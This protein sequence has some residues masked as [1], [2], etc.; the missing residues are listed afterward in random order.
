MVMIPTGTE[1][2]NDRAGEG[3]QQFTE[4]DASVLYRKQ[5]TYSAQTAAIYAN[6]AYYII[7]FYE[8]KKQLFIH[9]VGLFSFACA[10]P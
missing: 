1:T 10:A 9:P 2:K 4:L 5:W 3:Q 7:A 6:S 8:K